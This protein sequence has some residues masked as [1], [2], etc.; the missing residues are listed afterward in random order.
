[1]FINEKSSKEKEL[2]NFLQSNIKSHYLQ[3][4]EW[5]Q[6]KNNWEHELIVIKKDEKII[7]T[8]SV[9]LKKFPILN[10]Y[11]M[12]APRG[13]VCNP[14][15]KETL[16]KM[17]KEVVKIAKKYNAFVFKMDPDIPDNDNFKDTMLS[18]GYKFTVNSKTIQPKFVYRLNIKDKTEEELLKSFRTKTRYNINLAIRKNVKIREA[19]RSDIP[20]FYD[21]LKFTAKRDQ[22]YVRDIEYYERVFDSMGAEHVKIFIA[23]CE[24]EPVAVAMSIFYGNKMWYLYGG[25]LNKYRNYMPTY[26]LQWEM[27]KWAKKK[28]CDIYD[29]GGVS[30]YK[31]KNNPMYGVYHFKKGFN[32]EV[33]EF[34]D[35]L[36]MI[37]KPHVNNMYNIISACYNRFLEAKK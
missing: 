20:I 31:C 21:I 2:N 34:T 36:Y 5:A 27:I 33:V 24:K 18:L 13:F 29:F 32:G 1:M 14:N 17:T 4:I 12:Y 30:G 15:D 9:L 25:S 8:M 7:G 26:L 28:K 23:E 10:S 19:Q 35:E 22:F 6:V 11:M 16:E 3:T 37:F